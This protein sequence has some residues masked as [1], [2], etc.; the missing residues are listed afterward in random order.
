MIK[1]IHPDVI[2]KA[3]LELSLNFPQPSKS[4]FIADPD[5]KYKLNTL[6]Y[7]SPEFGPVDMLAIG[8]SQTVGLG[9]D[10]EDIWPNLVAD[11][12]GMS[13]ANLGIVGNSAQGMFENV[14]AYVKEYGAPKVIFALYPSMYRFKTLL[15]K[16]MNTAIYVDRS[17][18]TEVKN[19]N[20]AFASEGIELEKTTNYARRPYNLNDVLAYEV[21]L[22]QS[23]MA[24]NALIEYCRAADILLIM[25]TWELDT[26]EILKEQYEFAELENLE[27][28]FYKPESVACHATKLGDNKN[29][30]RD[31][32]GHMGSHQHL[33]FAELF[34]EGIKNVL[35]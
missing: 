9:V 6:G 33:H 7:R 12:T 26:N 3:Q 25:S 31:S 11:L 15:R 34:I 30:G 1:K 32:S 28:F 35:A 10:E 23:V 13:H 16:D 20:L 8:C 29:V 18:P 27:S 22:Y 24:V 4:S 5:T 21:G 19:I 2:S 14:L 17:T